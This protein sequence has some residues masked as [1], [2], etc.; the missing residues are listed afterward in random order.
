M[1][2]SNEEV[3][4]NFM[5]SVL[6]IDPIEKII[7]GLENH[8]YGDKDI[9][10]LES[11]L[12]TYTNMASESLGLPKGLGN[13]VIDEYPKYIHSRNYKKYFNILLNYYKSLI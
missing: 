10:F 11:K 3:K 5:I 2:K 6:I 9:P 13:G 4:D 8:E 7:N 12:A 1:L